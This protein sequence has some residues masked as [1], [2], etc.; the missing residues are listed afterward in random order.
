M[1][2]QE[3]SDA[4]GRICEPVGVV[5]R[6]RGRPVER[7]RG[8]PDRDDS[9]AVLSNDGLD[10]WDQVRATGSVD[11]ETDMSEQKLEG[12]RIYRESYASVA[13]SPSPTE[14]TYFAHSAV[15]ELSMTF[16]IQACAVSGGRRRR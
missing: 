16:T 1:A 13:G 2:A 4:E 11:D 12:V 14:A 6:S 15:R 10:R 8:G 5:R 7:A 9:T 3:S